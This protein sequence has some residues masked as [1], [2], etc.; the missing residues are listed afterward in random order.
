[1][2]PVT[3]CPRPPSSC[4]RNSGEQSGLGEQCRP[5]ARVPVALCCR[6]SPGVP[7]VRCSPR[8][9][10]LRGGVIPAL[11][12][13]SHVP[14]CECA[15]VV[16]LAHTHRPARHN[17]RRKPRRSISITI[18]DLFG[19]VHICSRAHDPAFCNMQLASHT[20]CLPVNGQ[21]QARCLT[22]AGCV[23][24]KKVNRGLM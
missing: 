5:T 11:I 21:L 13:H 3:L 24:F 14:G 19:R 10:S 17:A 16:L 6:Q 15:R 23:S 18:T 4:C 2:R 8:R 20:C 22:M 9:Q 12:Q 7:P 1:M